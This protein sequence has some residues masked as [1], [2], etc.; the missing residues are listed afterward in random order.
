MNHPN[1]HSSSFNN[2][3]M[4]S[5]PPSSSN[6]SQRRRRSNWME[7]EVEIDVVL[8]AMRQYIQNNF[9]ERVMEIL[10]EPV[11]NE[12]MHFTLSINIKNL[13]DD[14]PTLGNLVLV[15]P[16]RYI[17]LFNEAL[18]S[19]LTYCCSNRNLDEENFG[20]YADRPGEW[21]NKRN[22]H[23]R[24]INL[25][26]CFIKDKVSDIRS[27]DYNRLIQVSGT[28]VRTLS[29]QMLESMKT[30]RCEG[31]T[32]NNC[33]FHVPADVEQ[34][35]AFVAPKKCPSDPRA[36]RGGKPCNCTQFE[37]IDERLTDFQEIRI[38]ENVSKLS[39]GSMPRS[40][41]VILQDDLVDFAKAGDD[42]QIVG[43]VRRRWEPCI[44]GVR[45]RLELM[46][47]AISA[48]VTNNVKGSGGM[49]NDTLEDLKIYWQEAKESGKTIRARNHI[50]KSFCPQIYGLYAVK[51]ALALVL[52][53][54]NT[55]TTNDG[56]R[57]RGDS[58]M[59][60]V[61]DPGTGKSQFLKF[62]LKLSARAVM[63]TGTGTTSAGLTC[64]AAKVQGGW[65]LEAGALV[66]A[67]RGVCCIDEFSAIREHD[68]ATIHEAMEQQTLSVAKAGLVCK[69]NTRATIIAA[70]NPKGKY[71]K[72]ESLSVN[73]AIATPLLSRF[74]VVLVLLDL[75]DPDWDKTVST[76]I[77]NNNL[78]ADE[79]LLKDNDTNYPDDHHDEND[80]LQLMTGSSTSS[81]NQ[82]NMELWSI[83]RLSTYLHYIKENVH[84]QLTPDA[85]EILSAY[86]TAQRSRDAS[87]NQG[88]TTIRF[89]ES[90]IRLAQAHAKIC[91]KDSVDIDD[92]VAAVI[93]LETSMSSCSILGSDNTLHSH[94]PD[95]PDEDFN[96]QKL[97]CLNRLHLNDLAN[98][99]RQE[100]AERIASA[101]YDDDEDD[102]DDE[103]EHD[104]E[105]EEDGNFDVVINNNENNDGSNENEK[106][107]NNINSS[108]S[109]SSRSGNV[110]SS[111]DHEYDTRPVK[112]QKRY[113]DDDD[114]SG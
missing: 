87:H 1:N 80:A 71:D 93:L 56:L 75:I 46:I 96:I 102:D 33:E 113:V 38:Q 64:A 9:Q 54:G 97:N 77:L 83:E 101:D 3:N 82:N 11:E 79:K 84:P 114:D 44:R 5:Q 99:V 59:L 60:L 10:E 78:D 2:S 95:N 47:D 85:N 90:L 61:G 50:I 39:M 111:N 14:I 72:D 110:H 36:N 21:I 19:W 94:F 105:I 17:H 69:L 55:M 26:D 18:L 112:K 62:A 57:L 74:D 45:C 89:L 16:T 106:Y 68:R 86:Y 51:L 15:Y 34:G 37:Q 13:S 31:R 20:K 41:S 107:N 8:G 92:A 65:V 29:V 27:A 40:I 104:D 12:G 108:S 25:P 76:F 7:N 30:F 91:F 24:I 52:T 4:N 42:V 67:D 22:V 103:E 73:T 32:C 81:S 35:Y 88:R 109:S 48:R 28:I 23:V 53:G 6:P 100:E 66:L 49:T 63:T 98:K 70:S 58:H 43:Y